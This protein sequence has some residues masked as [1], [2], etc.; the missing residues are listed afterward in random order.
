LEN[1]NFDFGDTSAFSTFRS[2]D[3]RESPSNSCTA[4]IPPCDQIIAERLAAN[5]EHILLTNTEK[6]GNKLYS[7][8]EESL[9]D[10]ELNGLLQLPSF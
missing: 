9:F 3:P 1:L 10:S 2:C 6:K 8:F 5:V 7:E 4:P